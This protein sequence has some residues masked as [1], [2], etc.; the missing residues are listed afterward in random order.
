[1]RFMANIENLN[2]AINCV[3]ISSDTFVVSPDNNMMLMSYR[4]YIFNK[5]RIFNY[6]MNIDETPSMAKPAASCIKKMNQN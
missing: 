2:S 3:G 6:A 4:N 1:M 5:I